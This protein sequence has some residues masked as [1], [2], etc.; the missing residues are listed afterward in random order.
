[1]VE[2]AKEAIRAG[3]AF[4]IV[5]SQRF[6]V[7][8]PAD[9]L[10]VYRAL[11]VSQP[12][13]TCFG[14]RTP[15]GRP[16]RG[17]LQPRGAHQGHGRQ[18]ITH[19]IAGSRPRG[20]SPEHDAHLAEDLLGD[21]KERAEHLMLVDLRATTS[22]GSAGPEPSTVGFA[23]VRRYSHIMHIESTVVGELRPSARRTTPWSRRFRPARFPA[24]PSHGP[25]RSSTATRGCDGGSTAVWWIPRLRGGPRHGHRHPDRTH[26][27]RAGARASGSGD[28]R[29]LVPHLEYEETVNKAAPRC[30]PWPQPPA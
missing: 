2:Q 25:W 29:G 4:Q 14:C 15:T 24:R 13:C 21:A 10:D 20:K 1:M 9:A 19:P 6:T 8:C 7:P 27:G 3:E 22:S 26:Q 18:A 16:R 23:S 28:R 30:A 17:G 12:P 11:R 5:V